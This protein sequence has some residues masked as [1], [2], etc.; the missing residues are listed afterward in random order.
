[1]K[2]AMALTA[3]AL[4]AVGTMSPSANAQTQLG[5][6]NLRAQVQQGAGVTQVGCVWVW[7]YGRRIWVCR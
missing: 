1:M 7:R 6:A 5:A 4:C 2:L 3:A